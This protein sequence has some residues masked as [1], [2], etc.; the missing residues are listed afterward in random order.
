MGAAAMNKF[1]QGHTC[2]KYC[3]GLKKP[4]AVI[5]ESTLPTIDLNGSGTRT[6]TIAQTDAE[7]L[8]SIGFNPQ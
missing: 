3:Q 2:N 6:M 5:K 8:K 7:L 1:F 4:E